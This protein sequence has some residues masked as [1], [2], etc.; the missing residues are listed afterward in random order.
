MSNLFDSLTRLV[1]SDLPRRR[2]I[3]LTLGSLAAAALGR[4]AFATPTCPKGK[5]PDKAGNCCHAAEIDKAGFCCNASDGRHLD[6]NGNCCAIID[7]YG[8]CKDEF[9]G[10]V[11]ATC[12]T[13]I[14]CSSSD[15]DCVCGSVAQGGGFCV[16]G[17]TPCAGLPTCSNSTDCA[18]CSICLVDTCC[19]AG[20]C[21]PTDLE[22]AATSVKPIKTK[23]SGPTIAHR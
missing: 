17:S 18:S 13:F 6:P 11:A 1:G 16:P 12:E 3:K 9:P 20:V 21:V 15:S 8:Y 2:M 5:V 19:G 7:Q 4:T 14:P 23:T 22:C 10:C